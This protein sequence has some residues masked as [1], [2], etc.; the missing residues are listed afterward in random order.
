MRSKRPWDQGE[1]VSQG[2]ARQPVAE[3]ELELKS[4]TDSTILYDLALELL[5]HVPIRIEPRT[6]AGRG[7]AL[8][9][10]DALTPEKF[11]PL[12]LDRGQSIEAAMVD[13]LSTCLR[14]AQ[15][16]AL[17]VLETDNPEGVHQMR[18]AL[19]R[20]RSA[21]GL[22][23]TSLPQDQYAA[24]NAEVKWLAGALGPVR[25]WDVFAETIYAPVRTQMPSVVIDPSELDTLDDHITQMRTDARKQARSAVGSARSTAFFLRTGRWISRREW[26]N[27]PLSERGA[28]LFKPAPEASRT[29]LDKCLRKAAKRGKTLTTASA[30]ERHEFRIL[31]KKLRYAADFLRPLYPPKATRRFLERLAELQDVLGGL[32]DVAA[33]DTLLQSLVSAAAEKQRQHLAQA[34]G[35][36]TGW[37]AHRVFSAA[38]QLPERW[39]DVVSVKPFWR[40]E[41]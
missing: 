30:E 6:K 38:E 20:F 2:G 32:N 8:I 15:F 21:L 22:F 39:A 16:N 17:V 33:A 24:I 12:D 1:I 28:A 31:I 27:Q 36:V 35:L 37:H 13:I 25:D 40:Q 26:R 10:G 3:L 23:R 9:Q 29:I 4:G 5:D 14:L 34:S 7:F 41:G 19:R 11:V 18:V